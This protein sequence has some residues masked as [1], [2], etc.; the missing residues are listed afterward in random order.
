MGKLDKKESLDKIIKASKTN[1]TIEWFKKELISILSS[2]DSKHY[3]GVLNDIISEYDKNKSINLQFASAYIDA[4]MEN[5]IKKT[6]KIEWDIISAWKVILVRE[7][8]LSGENK[9]YKYKVAKWAYP[10]HIRKEFIR[11]IGWSNNNIKI[12]NGKWI[13]Y[14]EERFFAKW[15]IVYIKVPIDTIFENLDKDIKEKI[16]IQEDYILLQSE[17]YKELLKRFNENQPMWK[18]VEFSFWIPVKEYEDIDK[19]LESITTK[20]TLDPSK[21]EI[22]LLLNRPNA[23]IDFDKTTKDK[24]V[25]FKKAHPEYNIVLFE[26]TFNFKD[27]AKMGEIYKLLWDTII[28]RNIQR[29]NIKWMDMNKI[30]NLI[31]KTWWADS[32]D[33]NPNYLQN[34]LEK[35]SKR[36]NWKELVRLTWESRIPSEL[37]KAYPLIEID[38]FFQRYYDLEYVWWDPLKRDVWIWS[39]KAWAYTSVK[40]FNG[41]A[42]IQED[43]N[44]VKRIKKMVNENNDKICMHHDKNF[45]WAVDNSTDRGICARI[46]IWYIVSS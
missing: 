46:I 20:Q 41:D 11:Q 9:V 18:N 13:S 23:K 44:F 32:T 1:S 25:K 35:Y 39:Y 31:I 36:Y 7:R 5:P 16:K 43:T 19:T 28:Y 33:K 4:Y 2:T 38:E 17:D 3:E 45:V 10:R 12:T 6:K 21:Y 26:H 40:W 14:P 42:Y 37:A 15:D 27:K 30:R 29:K 24:I 34:Q 22:V 8:D